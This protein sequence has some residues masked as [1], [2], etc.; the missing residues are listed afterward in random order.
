MSPLSEKLKYDPIGLVCD[1]FSSLFW[2]V[3]L[4]GA[5]VVMLLGGIGYLIYRIMK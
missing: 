1:W 3:F 2:W 4:A 5:L